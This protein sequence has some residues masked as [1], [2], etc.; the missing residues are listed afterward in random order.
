MANEGESPPASR[1]RRPCW[2]WRKGRD[3][4]RARKRALWVGVLLLF[5][6]P[7]L[8]LTFDHI[9]GK[10]ALARY[11]K[12]LIAQGE[13]LTIFEC[14]PPAGPPGENGFGEFMRAMALVESASISDNAPPSLREMAPGKAWVVR[15][16]TE[17]W[18]W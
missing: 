15:D 14:Q 7:F 17:W 16:A 12:K 2:P 6:S 1:K 8:F 11:K 3:M 9:R 4:T 18:K 5:A 10:A 13:K